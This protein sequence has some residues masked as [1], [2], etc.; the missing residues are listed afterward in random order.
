M[1]E[2]LENMDSYSEIFQNNISQEDKIT[3]LIEN[4]QAIEELK[5]AVKKRGK[6]S[7]ITYDIS[8]P[9][10]D[11]LS[12]A[13]L[14]F[15]KVNMKSNYLFLVFTFY[16]L[17]FFYLLCFQSDYDLSHIT[18]I[19]NEPVSSNT[20]R[21]KD[22][23]KKIHTTYTKLFSSGSAG[24]PGGVDGSTC[25]TNNIIII[26]ILNDELHGSNIWGIDFGSSVGGTLLTITACTEFHMVGIEVNRLYDS[27]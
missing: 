21:H 25:D 3:L 17:Y 24:Q 27:M 9:S 10:V 22:I 13:G 23:Q 5:I 8:D 19:I 6:A 2:I 12:N 16:I 11:E 26:S 15:V 4:L 14:F 7:N 18:E 1:N 20:S